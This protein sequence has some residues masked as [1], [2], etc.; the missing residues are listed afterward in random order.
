MINT[1]SK[2]RA[3]SVEATESVIGGDEYSVKYATLSSLLASAADQVEGIRG[4]ERRTAI[5]RAWLAGVAVVFGPDSDILEITT[6][7]LQS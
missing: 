4:V 1:A 2:I 5:L 6:R 3:R 7:W